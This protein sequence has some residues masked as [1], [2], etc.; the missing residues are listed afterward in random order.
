MSTICISLSIIAGK[1]PWDP[2][3]VHDWDMDRVR[4]FLTMT[5]FHFFFAHVLQ[6]TGFT[7]Q[8]FGPRK[9]RKI[10]IISP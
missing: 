4:V 6:S 7:E 2:N 10:K 9:I 1:E 5:V 3:R 8:Q